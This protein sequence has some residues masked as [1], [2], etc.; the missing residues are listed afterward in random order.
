MY[1]PPINNISEEPFVS[2]IMCSY[3]TFG[4][5]KEA[6]NSIINQTYQNFELII[7]DD[8][9]TDGTK[10]WLLNIV[11]HSKIKV[12]FHDVNIGYVANKNF[13]IQQAKGDFITQNDSDDSSDPDR[14]K[15][16]VGVISNYPTAKIIATGFKLIDTSGNILEE[17]SA[18]EEG[19]IEKQQGNYPFWFP[20]LLI[21]KSLFTEFGYFTPLFCGMGDDHYWIAKANEKYPIYCLKDTLYNYRTNPGS[22][23]NVLND[24]RKLYIS[25][26]IDTLL[27]QRTETGTDWLEQNKF[28]EIEIFER[29]LRNDNK[30]MSER[31]RMWAA[32]HIDKNHLNT[33]VK[34][35]KQSFLANPTNFSAYRTLLYL[36][37]KKLSL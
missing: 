20:G 6:V 14:L 33:A 21:H 29:R 8:G 2:I 12:F 37:K 19:W 17:V 35:L 25:N 9:S 11:N 18:K 22:I 32:K 23:T 3:N 31:Y 15:K 4:Y 28:E 26:L 24:E 10:E 16:Q 13:A 1:K 36:V 7:S 27:Q 34:L 30:F 5:I